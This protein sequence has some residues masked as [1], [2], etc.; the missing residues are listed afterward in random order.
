MEVATFDKEDNDVSL[1]YYWS[2]NG[3]QLSETSDTLSLSDNF[4]RGD[5]IDLTVVPD[6]GKRKGN[7]VSVSIFVAN[8]PPVINPS[9][10]TSKFDRKQ[11]SHQVKAT[12][13]DGDPLTYALKAGPPGMTIDASTG[14]ITWPVPTDFKGTA[15]ITVS[16]TD[17]YGGETLESFTVNI[18]P[19]QK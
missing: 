1:T 17:G 10:E 5:K 13:P 2:K 12:D 11:F 14:L 3:S 18:P 6:D 9:D 16:V 7:P 8:S 4:K 19:A 15:Q